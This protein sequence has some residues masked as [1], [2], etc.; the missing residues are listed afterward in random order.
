MKNKK[1]I[2]IIAGGISMVIIGLLVWYYFKRKK[3][4]AIFDEINTK[5]DQNIGTSGSDISGAL[6]SVEAA[7]YNGVDA[8][9]KTINDA[10]G[11]WLPDNDTAIFDTLR[12]K[13][14]SQLK[15]LDNSMLK[16]YGMT[17]D[18]KIKS[19]FSA[20]VDNVGWDCGKYQQA[21]NMINSAK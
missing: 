14:K 6:F 19:I 8:D 11:G 4:K 21:L 3:A 12:G 15:A 16:N 17:L 9:A 13:T 18:Q 20:C 5:L 7:D 2:W 1:I 10:E